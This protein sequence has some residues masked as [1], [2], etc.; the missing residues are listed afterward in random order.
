MRH[1]AVAGTDAMVAAAAAEG[2]SVVAAAKT[3][4]V[5]VVVIVVVVSAQFVAVLVNVLPHCT[6][7]FLHTV[8]AAWGTAPAVNV[9]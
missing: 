8:R 1:A 7:L 2:V 4:V 3:V 9:T 5:V 6:A